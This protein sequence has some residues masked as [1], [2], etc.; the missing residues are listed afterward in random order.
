MLIPN[1]A[2]E[3]SPRWSP[4][5]KH[6][7]FVSTRNGNQEIYSADADG[8]NVKRLTNEPAMDNNP[9]WSPDGSQLAF[10]SARHGNFEIYTMKADGSDVPG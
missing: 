10:C 6:I 7:A 9:S 2:F 4:D 3:E 5:G 1:K 8:K